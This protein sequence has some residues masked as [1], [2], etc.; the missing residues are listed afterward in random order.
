MVSPMWNNVFLGTCLLIVAI[1]VL[2]KIVGNK[3]NPNI[4]YFLWSFVA[5]RILLP[6]HFIIALPD[7]EVT[8]KLQNF[9]PAVSWQQDMEAEDIQELTWQGNNGQITGQEEIGISQEE[10]GVIK[11]LLEP[12]A[13]YVAD[14]LPLT[15][16]VQGEVTTVGGQQGKTIHM[17]L[18]VLWVCGALGM[19][20]FL[21]VKNVLFYRK[22]RGSRK[23]VTVLENGLFVYEAEG[24]N[25]LIGCVKPAIYLSPEVL[26]DEKLKEHVLKH[27]LQHYRVK[28]HV[29]VL[30]RTLC[31]IVQWY[32]PLVWVAY[33][34]VSKDCELACD[35]RVTK[36][37][38]QGERALYGESLLAVVN[39]SLGKSR[40][41]PVTSMG[42]DKKFFVKRL[43]V[44][45]SSKK[46]KM[47]VIPCVVI[48]LVGIVA[49]TTI[50][51]SKKKEETQ[52][53]GTSQEAVEQENGSAQE[54]IGSQAMGQDTVS[55]VD[56]RKEINKE[57]QKAIKERIAEQAAIQRELEKELENAQDDAMKQA[58]AAE[59]AEQKK[60]LAELEQE[61]KAVQGNAQEEELVQIQKFSQEDMVVIP[62]VPVYTYEEAAALGTMT[63]VYGILP[64]ASF[65]T[66][67]ITVVDGIE[68]HFGKYD[69]QGEEES[70]QVFG[71]GYAI[72]NEKY[73]LNNGL[74]VG[75]SEAE[76]LEQFPH[77][78]V[79]YFDNTP[80]YEKVTGHQ[81]WNETAYPRSTAWLENGKDYSWTE[82]YDYII[83]GDIEQESYDTL[84]VYVG[85]LMKDKAVKAITFYYP[86][87]G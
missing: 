85:L 21:L 61:L 2:R 27:E 66:W 1:L 48:L 50:T 6:V 74:Q 75:M 84:P 68:Y 12:E 76:V 32:N 58:I 39:V 70:P 30:V 57:M 24:L 15:P 10:E 16:N 8:E 13:G 87:A 80:V 62:E 22:L 44:I 63:E 35:Y 38:S 36:E 64:G 72:V 43:E 78:A 28:D 11:L 3:L 14:T 37:M 4:Q 81:G 82:Q 45:M 71:F 55:N 41:Y 7:T 83:I 73:V 26:Q 5:L 47:L 33:F 54:A 29:W 31:L 59:I 67:Y 20:G 46:G 60:L 69:S 18:R 65:G 51:Y 53:V 19:G 77:M 79:K 49:F 23:P 52:T 42:E 9:L 86:T 34:E 17:I 56:D 40:F 25:C